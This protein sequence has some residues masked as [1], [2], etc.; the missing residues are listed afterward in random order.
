[1]REEIEAG[2]GG[3]GMELGAGDRV[4]EVGAGGDGGGEGVMVEPEVVGSV[5]L[6]EELEGA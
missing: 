4:T 6:V 3:V 2:T 5:D 1:M